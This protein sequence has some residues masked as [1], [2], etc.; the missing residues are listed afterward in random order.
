MSAE[1]DSPEFVSSFV[2]RYIP[3]NRHGTVQDVAPIF[4]FLASDEASFITGETFLLDGG[5]L[6]GQ[7]PGAELLAKVDL[8]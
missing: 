3:L 2:D 1:I 7:K 8:G 4:L 6:A 5:Q